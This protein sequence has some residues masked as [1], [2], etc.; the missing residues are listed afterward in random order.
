MDGSAGGK[1]RG[2]G[3]EWGCPTKFSLLPIYLK[4]FRLPIGRFRPLQ[5]DIGKLKDTHT[6]DLKLGLFI[7]N[8][9]SLIAK[10]SR[11]FNLPKSVA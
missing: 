7:K 10:I 9:G 2:R 11:K 5:I 3:G 4:H 8:I 1:E 6:L